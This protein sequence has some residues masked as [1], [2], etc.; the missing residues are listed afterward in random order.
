MALNAYS[1]RNFEEISIELTSGESILW[2]GQPLARVVFHRSDWFA[3]PFTF[4]WG[5]FAVFWEH[6]ALGSWNPLHVK[7]GVSSFMALWGVPFVLMGQ[8]IIWGRF[9]YTAWKKRRTYYALTS[10]RI[11]VVSTGTVRRVTDSYVRSIQSVVLTTRPDGIGTIEFAPEPEQQ[12]FW[13][14]P[15][16]SNRGPQLM[17]NLSRLV[18]YNIEDAKG[19]YRLI[20]AQRERSEKD[21]AF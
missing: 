21:R 16:W 13:G 20:Q 10:K 3:V 9:F 4:L 6:L 11:L 14:K 8:Y 5:G 15:N 7:G 1:T 2:I 19:V 12:S 18:F 17:L